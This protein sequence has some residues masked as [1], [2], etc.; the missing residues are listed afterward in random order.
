MAKNETVPLKTTPR[1]KPAPK[2][3][4]EAAYASAQ[5]VKELSGAVSEL[6]D[7]VR[8]LAD[9]SKA[10][11]VPQS[12]EEVKQEAEVTKAGPVKELVNPA[13]IEK[14]KE[15]IGEAVD[16]CEVFYPRSG[17]TIF[18]VVIKKELSNA[19]V[20]Y[21]ER[22]KEDRRSREIGN[23]GIDGVEAWCKLIRDNLKRTRQ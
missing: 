14:A 15:I 9:K 10:P 5:E 3:K 17:G 13:W 19:P 4:V 16:H 12:A 23:E 18:T 22:Y 21:L 11:T 20:D 7:M 2:P 1:R 6:I 8:G